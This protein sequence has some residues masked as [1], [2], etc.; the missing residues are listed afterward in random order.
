M[1]AP[2]CA[3]RLHLL[4]LLER[5]GNVAVGGEKRTLPPPQS[6]PVV[7]ETGKQ[8]RGERREHCRRLL[9][10][11]CCWEGRETSPWGEKG[12]LPPP[13]S[14][15]ALGKAGTR[16][17]GERRRLARGAA[18]RQPSS[19]MRAPQARCVMMASLKSIDI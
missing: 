15:P 9:S 18:A 13:P 10:T 17:R 6:T 11:S 7:G 2:G 4:P 3:R 16:R 1:E 14:T 12:T 5:P 19:L 8:R